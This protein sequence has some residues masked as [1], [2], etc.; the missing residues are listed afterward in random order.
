MGLGLVA[1]L[2]GCTTCSRGYFSMKKMGS[3]FE[4]QR[5]SPSGTFGTYDLRC[6][7]WKPPW[8]VQ[9]LSCPTKKM[10]HNL[11]LVE[12]IYKRNINNSCPDYFWWDSLPET[13]ARHLKHWGWFKRVSYSGL[14]SPDRS[15]TL[16]GARK[17][18]NLV[19]QSH[20]CW[21]TS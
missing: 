8:N 15:V 9:G 4:T 5:D 12:G 6:S 14:R 19:H 2:L 10:R 21:T 1:K 11:K 20:T 3:Q 7:D 17:A 13:N 16:I 18:C